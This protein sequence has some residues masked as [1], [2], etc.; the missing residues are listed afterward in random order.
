MQS[1]VPVVVE[2]EA[3]GLEEWRACLPTPSGSARK[4]TT[5][6]QQVASSSRHMPRCSA[7]VTGLTGS[8]LLSSMRTFE[9]LRQVVDPVSKPL[10]FIDPTL[11]S[12]GLDVIVVARW[13]KASM[14]RMA[15]N[16]QRQHRVWL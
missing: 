2:E 8:V 14:D 3:A 12:S 9:T 16:Q 1:E 5:N 15:Q 10:R 7:K 6:A 11:H 4:H 13:A